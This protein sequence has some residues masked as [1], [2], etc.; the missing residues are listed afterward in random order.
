MTGRNKKGFIASRLAEIALRNQQD[1]ST[2]TE[3]A[4]F[5][6]GWLNDYKERAPEVGKAIAALKEA[7]LA[8]EEADHAR[9]KFD[10]RQVGWLVKYWIDGK[11][12]D[13]R[14]CKNCKTKWFVAHR[15]DHEY[16][17]EECRILFNRRTPAAKEASRIRM[18]NARENAKVRARLTQEALEQSEARERAEKEATLAAAKRSTS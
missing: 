11:L 9:V 8:L 13:L 12:D 4:E 6:Y 3:M 16:C 5:F 1:S 14:L 18:A 7:S 17:T 10:P 15:V 2:P